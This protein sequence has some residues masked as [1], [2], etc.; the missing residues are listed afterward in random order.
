MSRAERAARCLVE[1]VVPRASPMHREIVEMSSDRGRTVRGVAR[2]RDLVSTVGLGL[3]LRSSL[4]TGGDRREVI[5]QGASWAS[6]V[7]LSLVVAWTAIDVRS[8]TPELQPVVAGLVVVGVLVV[9]GRSALAR[10]PIAAVV[11][12]LAVV[13]ALVVAVVLGAPG[14]ARTELLVVGSAVV[15]AA[16]LAAGWFDPRL[17]VVATSVWCWR[18]ASLDLAQL[19]SGVESLAGELAV[20]SVVVRWVAMAGGVIAGWL[21]THQ[22]L[23]RTREI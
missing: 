18:F 11:G 21:V 8:A 6:L 13:V 15:P 3:Q 1:R 20:E 10:V 23:A 9:V 12:R 2:W 4:A 5:A 22:S 7:V 14:I 19:A 16:V 17:A